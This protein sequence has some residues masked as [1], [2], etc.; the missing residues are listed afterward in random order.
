MF[1]LLKTKT[2]QSLQK[3]DIILKSVEHELSLLEESL[4][5]NLVSGNA[6]LDRMVQYVFKS[7]GKRLRPAMVFLFAKAL[8]RGY[9]HP[10][11]YELA[12]AVEM[13][14]TASILHDDVIDDA[15]TRRGL[16]TVGRKW[17]SKSAIIAGDYILSKAL[18]KLVSV[19]N[20]AVEIFASTLNELCIG[21]IL[22]KNQKYKVISLDEYINKSERKTAKLFMAGVECAVSIMSGSNNLVI[23][24]AR[25]YALNYGVAFQI[26]DDIINFTGCG[27]CDLKDGIIT[28]PVLFAV[29]E[30]EQKSDKTLRKLIEKGLKKDKDF[31]AAMKLVI[32]SGG[33][34][35]SRHLALEYANKAV[36]CLRS[37]EDSQYK[38]A[39][40]SLASYT[41][42][43]N[44]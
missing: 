10:A 3:P 7:G 29:Q 14:H 18:T 11:H 21:E 30:Y 5:K 31:K 12:E 20:I 28:A 15:E 1:N 36:D 41:V 2:Q 44:K 25:G 33:M 43:R 23:K 38:Q 26:T 16:L 37:M 17:G 13:I 34:E 39:L 24:A 9:V 19:G 8:G 4:V 42:E 32:S 6:D 40:A 35:K 22:Q 27:G